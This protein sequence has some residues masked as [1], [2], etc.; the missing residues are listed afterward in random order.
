M[1]PWK[2]KTIYLS[3]IGLGA[4]ALLLDRLFVSH[5]TPESALASDT[6]TP[7]TS[8]TPPA[9]AEAPREMIPEIPF[10]RGVRPW[11]P[12]SGTRDL[13]DPANRFHTDAAYKSG[14]FEDPASNAARGGKRQFMQR[15][16]LNGVLVQESL[17]IAVVDGR[18]MQT[19]QAL[20]DCTLKSVEGVAVTF[21]CPDGEAV[22]V[23]P[24]ATRTLA[25]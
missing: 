8:E 7:S 1:V 4:V 17:K 11:S 21:S 2:K 13:F 14:E 22:L 16:R 5:G 25:D 18:W 23:I 15:H 12:E 9:A 20:D 10:P 6:T 19:G 3:L 24:G